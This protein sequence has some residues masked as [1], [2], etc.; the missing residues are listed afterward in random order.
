[1]E[2]PLRTRARTTN[3]WWAPLLVAIAVSDLLVVAWWEGNV[4]WTAISAASVASLLVAAGWLFTRSR[5]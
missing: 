4:V 5:R 2:S 3:A 1:M